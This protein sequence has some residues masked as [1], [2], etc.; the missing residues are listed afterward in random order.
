[1]WSALS[2]DRTGLSFIVAAGSRQRSHSRVQ[3]PW[4]SWPLSQ[5][6][7][8]HFRRL[9]RLAGFPH[10]INRSWVWVILRPTVSRPVCLGIKPPSG[11]YDQ[12]HITVKTIAGFWYGAP[13]LT[14]G[15][16]CLLQCAMYNIQYI[17]LSQIWH[18]LPVFISPRNR[19]ARLY[20][21]ALGISLALIVPRMHSA[22]YN[23]ARPVQKT[24][25][26]RVIPLFTSSCVGNVYNF[27]SN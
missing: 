19:V 16:A 18:Q 23:L 13:F 24:Q 22:F 11:A 3:V 4:D 5:I 6:R 7:D 27:H 12:I 9:L 26:Q 20:P 25:S 21:Q 10:G 2:D 17:L 14:R 15:R 1:M 8:F